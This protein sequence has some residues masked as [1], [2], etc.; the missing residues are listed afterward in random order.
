MRR[1]TFATPAHKDKALG[2]KVMMREARLLIA[3][4]DDDKSASKALGRLL[5]AVR[6]HAETFVS[7][8]EFLK[9]AGTMPPGDD[10]K[11]KKL[12]SDSD[13]ASLA[14]FLM[15]SNAVPRQ[16]NGRPFGNASHLLRVLYGIREAEQPEEA[17]S[18][19]EAA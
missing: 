2:I 3:V 1:P 6:L 8:S 17:K 12:D 19:E 16:K 10:G 18:E 13:E 7:G 9:C 4:V 5:R 15:H 14:A 11:P